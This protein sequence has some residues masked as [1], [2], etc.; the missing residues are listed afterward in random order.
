MST[1][2]VF[3]GVIDEIEQGVIFLCPK[4]KILYIN[5]W[6]AQVGNVD[7]NAVEGQD[8]LAA[9]PLVVNTRVWEAVTDA[10]I[11]G[12]SSYISANLYQSPFEFYKH[13]L[14]GI[15]FYRIKQVICIKPL[16]LTNGEQGCQILIQDV[17]DVIEREAS[18]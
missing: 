3:K 4:T 6:I 8:F 10:L 18:L 11:F 7:R 16:E 15:E 1:V 13:G 5:D 2:P 17:S 12:L 9:F 14:F